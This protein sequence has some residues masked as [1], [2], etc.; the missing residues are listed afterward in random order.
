MTYLSLDTRIIAALMRQSVGRQ[1][2]QVE[3]QE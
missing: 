3:A 1:P 2:Q